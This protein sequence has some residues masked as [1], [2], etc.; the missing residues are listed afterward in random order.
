MESASRTQCR[1]LVAQ[2]ITRRSTEPKIIGSNPAEVG[3]F[4]IPRGFEN[5]CAG[6]VPEWCCLLDECCT[7]IWKWLEVWKRQSS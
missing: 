5:R 3:S 2:W 7:C 1:G 4:A 6:A